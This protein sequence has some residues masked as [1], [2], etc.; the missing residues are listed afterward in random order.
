MDHYFHT[1]MKYVQKSNE[2]WSIRINVMK[3]N[4][5]KNK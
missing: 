5:M 4:L 2:A 3:Y 1:E